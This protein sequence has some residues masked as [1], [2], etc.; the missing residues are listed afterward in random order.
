MSHAAASDWHS[1]WEVAVA[2]AISYFNVKSHGMMAE[3]ARLDVAVGAV[4]SYWN[5]APSARSVLRR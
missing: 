4:D 1:V 5:V 2:A 3:Q